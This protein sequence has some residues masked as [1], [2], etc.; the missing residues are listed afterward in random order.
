MEVLLL[1]NATLLQKWLFGDIILSV[2]LTRGIPRIRR[3]CRKILQDAEHRWWQNTYPWRCPVKLTTSCS[4]NRPRSLCKALA[5]LLWEDT[6]TILWEIYNEWHF[7]S[8]LFLSQIW[9][10]ATMAQL[11]WASIPS[12]HTYTHHMHPTHTTHT[13]THTHPHIHTY[14]YIHQTHTILIKEF[15]NLTVAHCCNL[16]YAQF[17]ALTIYT[18]SSFSSLTRKHIRLQ[19]CKGVRILTLNLLFF[20]R[21]K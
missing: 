13:P 2:M 3:F 15:I 4:F 17:L 6:F 18:F 16:T 14:T 10:L 19:G 9:T 7:F 8:A 5:Q 12:T 20:R 11:F 21:K 1:I